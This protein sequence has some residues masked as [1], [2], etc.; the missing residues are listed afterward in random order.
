MKTSLRIFLLISILFGTGCSSGPGQPIPDLPAFD[1]DTYYSYALTAVDEVLD[2]DPDN[3]EALGQ[4]A[5]L[6][7]RQ[8]QTNQALDCIRQAIDYDAE[9]PRYRLTYA[10]ALLLKGK[11]RDAFREAQRAVSRSGPSVALYETLAEASLRSN[12]YEDAIHYSDSAI[13]WSPHNAQNYLR[14][15]QAAARTRNAAV[16]EPTL[17]KGLSLGA[18]RTEV[19]SALISMYV[20][21][22]EYP[23]ARRYM[24]KMLS[25]GPVDNQ[26][27]LQQARILRMTGRS[28][29]SRVILNRLRADSTLNRTL[30]NQELMELHYQDRRYDSALYYARRVLEQ[31]PE[32]KAVMLVAAR[33]HD[34]NRAYQPAIRQYEA[35][36]RLD[37]LQ[38]PDV[39]QE[40]VLELG[41]LR[42]K[43]TYLWKR[44]QEEEF[45]KLKRLT[46][47]QRIAPE[48]TMIQETGQ[49]GL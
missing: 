13:A 12:Y 5:E 30:V 29:S 38:Q 23:R 22:E 17:L 10:R 26:V 20:E 48:G 7:L 41:K 15:G 18:D 31:Q 43:V 4:R 11:N 8:G 45:E 19:Y 1:E 46:P 37:S 6:L 42:R 2:R 24:R 25:E 34:G 39:H 9:E 40:A 33:S 27:R 47:L 3:A 16:A 32:D 28:D 21:T 49:P 35:I 44:K 14:K 36:V